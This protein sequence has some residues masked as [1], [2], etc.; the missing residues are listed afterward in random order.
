[1]SEARAVPWGLLAPRPWPR[2]RAAWASVL[3]RVGGA[4]AAS[5]TVPPPPETFQIHSVLY[6]MATRGGEG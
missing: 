5:W 1:M 6:A 4:I 2:A 3:F